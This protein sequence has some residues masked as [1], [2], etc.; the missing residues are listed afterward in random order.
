MKDKVRNFVPGII[1]HIYQRTASREVIFY[2]ISD[3]LVF[4][5]IICTQTRHF[6]VRILAL[7]PMPDHI[8]GAYIADSREKLSGFVGGY[9]SQFTRAHNP[10]CHCQG[11]LF[12]NPFGSAVK[13][14]AKKARANLIY[15]GNNPVERRLCSHAEKYR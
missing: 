4:F 1:H 10:V 13:V 8:H 2:S 3:Y 14:G 6:G 5:T 12:E 11:S 9:T 15:I 7:C